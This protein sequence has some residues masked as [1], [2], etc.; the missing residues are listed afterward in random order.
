MLNLRSGKYSRFC[1]CPF[2]CK[3]KV[4][5]VEELENEYVRSKF[6][7]NC[8]ICSICKQLNLSTIN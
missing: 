2:V 1:H 6:A 7:S 8:L 4:R 5:I 3:P